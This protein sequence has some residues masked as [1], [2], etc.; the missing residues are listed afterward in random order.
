VVDY[1]TTPLERA[2]QDV[3]L[4]LD[5]VGGATLRSSLAV[6]KRGSTLI[7]IAGLPP[8]EAA[9]KRGVRT[10]MSRGARERSLADV[11]PIHGG[12]P[13]HRDGAENVCAK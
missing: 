8:T 5:G 2:V 10:L 13:A 1:T 7:S 3:D 6:L 11:E 12:R 9:D 4:V